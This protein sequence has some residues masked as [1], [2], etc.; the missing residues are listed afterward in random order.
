MI[1]NLRNNVH[2]KRCKAECPRKKGL[3]KAPFSLSPHINRNHPIGNFPSCDSKS[4]IR[5]FGNQGSGT[6]KSPFCA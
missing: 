4:Q 6:R 3:S 5:K 2:I 1:I